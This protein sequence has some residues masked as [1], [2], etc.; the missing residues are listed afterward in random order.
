MCIY[1]CTLLFYYRHKR[2]KGLVYSF[3]KKKKRNQKDKKE[4]CPNENDF[5]LVHFLSW[6]NISVIVLNLFFFLCMLLFV[7]PYPFFKKYFPF[8]LIDFVFSLFYDF[9]CVFILSLYTI[10]SILRNKLEYCPSHQVSSHRIA[11]L[12]CLVMVGGWL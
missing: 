6:Y 8:S 1:G 3:S 4:Y 2:T 11:Y 9:V 5:L 12:F 7:Y 10:D